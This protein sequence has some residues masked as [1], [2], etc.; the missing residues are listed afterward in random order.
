MENF[1]DA[2]NVLRDTIKMDLIQL[3]VKQLKICKKLGINK[4]VNLEQLE[5]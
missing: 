1:M 2:A 4:L 5:L 3:I